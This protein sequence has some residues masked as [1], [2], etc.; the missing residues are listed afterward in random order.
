MLSLNFFAFNCYESTAGA[1]LL[2]SCRSFQVKLS[3]YFLKPCGASLS[4]SSEAFF[5][6]SLKFLKHFG[7]ATLL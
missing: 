4:T 2:N 3:F 5:L 7:G 1:P 6:F